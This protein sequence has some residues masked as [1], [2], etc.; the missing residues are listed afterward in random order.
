MKGSGACPECGTPLRRSNYRLQIFEDAIVEK[1][2][3]IRK[4][5]LREWVFKLLLV[6]KCYFMNSFMLEL[7]I[8]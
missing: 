8:R 2:I 6:I 3:D 5:I 4:R 7:K 1:E